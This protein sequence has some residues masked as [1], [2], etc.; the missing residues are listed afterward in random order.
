MKGKGIFIILA[1]LAAVVLIPVMSHAQFKESRS[2]PWQ[3]YPEKDPI[4]NIY[5]G[6]EPIEWMSWA[7]NPRFAVTNPRNPEDD[8]VLDKATGLVWQRKPWS[9]MNSYKMNW[10]R[11]LFSCHW[12]TRLGAIG[13]RLPTVEELSSLSEYTG[14]WRLP[15]GHPFVDLTD[16]SYWT[17]SNVIYDTPNSGVAY[18]VRVPGGVDTSS[19]TS[20]H[21]VWCVRGGTGPAPSC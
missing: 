8:I 19:K 10:S 9:A 21:G 6:G 16:N 4:W 11:A 20:T 5:Q 14:D 18:T 1:V 13:W 12:A 15:Y 2:S 17:S 3:S 7:N